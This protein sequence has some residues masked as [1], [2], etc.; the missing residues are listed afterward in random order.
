MNL[1]VGLNRFLSSSLSLLNM[2][3]F[4]FPLILFGMM[5]Y[6]G[7]DHCVESFELHVRNI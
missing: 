4:C 2:L 3:R 7:S 5:Y 1:G 6:F